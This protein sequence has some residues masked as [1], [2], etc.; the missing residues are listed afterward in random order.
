MRLENLIMNYY[1]KHDGQ[2]AIISQTIL[3]TSNTELNQMIMV[4]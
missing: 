1:T 3:G 4:R 2:N